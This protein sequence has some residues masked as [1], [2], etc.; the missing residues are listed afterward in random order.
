MLLLYKESVPSV[1][2]SG[3]F[4]HVKPLRTPPQ[5]AQATITVP[6]ECSLSPKDNIELV[7]VTENLRGQYT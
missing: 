7:K 1:T 6:T 2:F 4:A 5:K 3:T